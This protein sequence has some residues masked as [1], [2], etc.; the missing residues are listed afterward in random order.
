MKVI[1]KGHTNTHFCL[2]PTNVKS[3]FVQ[4]N[5]C[6]LSFS[7]VHHPRRSRRRRCRRWLRSQVRSPQGRGTCSWIRG[8][9][10]CKT[11][12]QKNDKLWNPRTLQSSIRII[13]SFKNRLPSRTA[14][15]T[16]F[17]IRNLTTISS[18]TRNPT[19]TS[20]PDPTALLSPMAAP[21][22]WPT[23]LTR[24]DT[25]LMSSSRE[26]PNTPNTSRKTTNQLPLTRLPLTPLPHTPPRFTLLPPT[27]NTKNLQLFLVLLA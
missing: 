12:N 20:S 18:T 21:K 11:Q 9:H 3:S 24:M 4:W 7:I 1:E 19:T 22:L 15:D 13:S 5:N 27:P 25:P 6:V 17:K 16:T 23:E 14:S 2:S 8:N 10:L 26:R